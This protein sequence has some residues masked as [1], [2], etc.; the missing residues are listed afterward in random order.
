MK[1]SE[2]EILHLKVKSNFVKKEAAYKNI[3][4]RRRYQR[5]YP[6]LVEDDEGLEQLADDIFPQAYYFLRQ[7]CPAVN[8]KSFT[9]MEWWRQNTNVSSGDIGTPR[10]RAFRS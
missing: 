8:K 2:K 6:E 5:V 1:D 7:D 3:L 10:F 9:I 4:R